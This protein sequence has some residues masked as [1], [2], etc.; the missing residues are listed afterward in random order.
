VTSST[1]PF[2]SEPSTELQARSLDLLPKFQTHA[3]IF[4]PGILWADKISETINLA[5]QHHRRAGQSAA[6]PFS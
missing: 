4:F 1:H 5:R 2:D 3:T 6:I